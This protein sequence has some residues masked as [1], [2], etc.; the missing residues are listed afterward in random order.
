MPGVSISGAGELRQRVRFAQP[1]TVQDDYGNVSTGWLT[2]FTVWAN[3]AP[4]LGGGEVV[5]GARLGGQQPVVIRVRQ[6]PDTRLV[7]TDWKVTDV[8]SGTEYNIRSIT[9]PDL[10]NVGHGKWVDMLAESGVAI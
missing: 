3:I 8:N 5:M 6:S 1:D 10:G 7:R 9:D 2:R 4:R